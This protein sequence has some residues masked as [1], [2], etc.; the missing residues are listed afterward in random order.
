MKKQVSVFEELGNNGDKDA[1]EFCT[2]MCVCVSTKK[3]AEKDPAEVMPG[4]HGRRWDIS[5]PAT[6][7][8]H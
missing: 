5:V 2:G 7:V 6:T 3:G 1:Q 4:K 8:R